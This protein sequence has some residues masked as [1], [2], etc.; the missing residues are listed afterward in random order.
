MVDGDTGSNSSRWISNDGSSNHY[1]EMDLEQATWIEKI[2]FW[3]DFNN[4]DA[5][6]SYQLEYF[7]GAS[8][9]EI[10]FKRR[11]EMAD[12]PGFVLDNHSSRP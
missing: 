5:L 8:W 2:K 1:I 9:H 12:K 4:S 11:C 10:T 3:T 7:S 6:G